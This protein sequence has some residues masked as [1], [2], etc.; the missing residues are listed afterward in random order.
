MRHGEKEC[1]VKVETDDGQVVE[2]RRKQSPSYVI[3]GQTFDRLRGGY[4]PEELHRALRLP[5]VDDSGDN[6]F[7]VHFG[8]QKAPI[9]LLGRSGSIAARFFATSSDAIRL[10]EVQ[11]RHKE[12]Y[13]NAKREKGLL[14]SESHIVNA[15]LEL[16][17]PVVELDDKLRQAEVLHDE[18]LRGRNQR[19]NLNESVKAIADQAEQLAVWQTHFEVLSRLTPPP[20]MSPVVPLEDLISGLELALRNVGQAKDQ[21]A[22]LATLQPAPEM[23]LVTPLEMLIDNLDGAQSYCEWNAD[24]VSAFSSIEPPPELGELS[25]LRDLASEL[26]QQIAALEHYHDSLQALSLLAAPPN[27]SITVAL[28]QTVEDLARIADQRSNAQFHFDALARLA[29]PPP[30]GDEAG[31]QQCLHSLEKAGRDRS[32][33]NAQ[34]Q[35]LNTVEPPSIADEAEALAETVDH[36]SGAMEFQQVKMA[37]FAAAH[38]DLARVEQNLRDMAT[39]RQC[40]ICGG[41]LDPDRVIA[42]AVFGIGDHLHE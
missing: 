32:F 7:D 10:V 4:L 24:L 39:D 19:D 27:L 16:L 22:A 41:T 25:T 5:S 36:L 1:S 29:P 35:L 18:I 8:M 31:L 21:V 42:Q 38:D 11:K 28:R 26:D 3:N 13:A 34:F 30:L 17:A 2:W 40:N 9:F 6:D 23:H 20:E 33:Y 14:D 15:R 37:A 12:K